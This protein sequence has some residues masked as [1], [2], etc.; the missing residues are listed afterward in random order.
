MADTMSR[1]TRISNSVV[2]FVLPAAVLGVLAVALFFDFLGAQ[3]TEIAKLINEIE[4]QCKADFWSS[5]GSMTALDTSITG[6][7]TCAAYLPKVLMFFGLIILWGII[8]NVMTLKLFEAVEPRA[9]RFII[10]AAVVIV[11]PA[12]LLYKYLTVITANGGSVFATFPAFTVIVIVE[13]ILIEAFFAYR[14]FRNEDF[15]TRPAVILALFLGSIVV[16]VAASLMFA[17]YPSN[18]FNFMGSINTIVF[19]LVLTYAFLGGLFYYGRATHIPFAALLL[20]WIFGLN[21][22]GLNN[23]RTVPAREVA[24]EPLKGN[25]QFLSW[26]QA[27]RDAAA[28]ATKEYPVYLVAASGG[29]IYAAMRTAYFLDFLQQK[30]PAF[31]HHIFAISGVSGGGLGALAFA[32]QQE[33]LT[34]PNLTSCDP[35][36]EDA[37]GTGSRPTPILDNFFAKDLISTVIGAGLFPDM[38]QRLIPWPIPSLDRARAF[39]KALG[40]NW[41]DALSV[42]QQRAPSILRK[43]A[44]LPGNCSTPSYFARCEINS[45]WTPNGDVPILIFNATEVDSGSPVVLS[46]LDPFF[47]ANSLAARNSPSFE[48]RSI[49]LVDGASLSARFPIALPAGFL[50]GFNNG[51]SL[52]LVDGGYFD[53]SGLST[54]Q[55]MKLALEEVA[56]AQNLK[57][58]VRIIFLGEKVP[59]VYDLLAMNQQQQQVPATTP[60]NPDAP[61]GAELSAHVKALFQARDQS[62]AETLRQAFRIDP[63]LIRFQWDPSLPPATDT[64]CS[65][66]PLAWYL[67]PCTQ[68][69]LKQR[70]QNA[71]IESVENFDTLRQDLSPQ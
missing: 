35:A 1:F 60:A 50:R 53:G 29:G 68:R 11:L 26:L 40:E 16:F 37:G 44:P 19:W 46:N 48:N 66:I 13:T 42:V 9:F 30:C 62:S 8:A 17:Y 71:V 33:S 45:Y 58:K 41:R 49:Y 23:T 59:S 39:R 3:A 14:F 4:I 70:L 55:A 2:F 31:A 28:F 25:Q 15:S 38:L 18:L 32:S 43:T 20:I 64:P 65:S 63:T 12:V 67:A 10:A 54:A 56:V 22:L 27:R 69:V 24:S 7:V 5:I 57:I 36:A 52:R 21:A 61:R 47:Y 51:T 34:E 6:N